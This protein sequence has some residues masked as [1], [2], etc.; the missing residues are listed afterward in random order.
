MNYPDELIFLKNRNAKQR[1]SQFSLNG[2]TIVLTGATSGIGRETAFRLAQDSIHLAIIIRD[3]QKGMELKS[4]IEHLTESKVSVFIADFSDLKSVSKVADEIKTKLDHIDV[5]IHNAGIHSTKKII[6]KDGFEQCFQINYLAS[7]L[8]TQ[9]LLPLL[10]TSKEST[11]L[12][13]NSE[14]HRFSS[15]D[16]TDYN[17]NKHHYTGLRAYGSSKTAQL[18]SVL[19]LNEDKNY[20]NMRFLCMHPGDVKSDIGKNN[21]FLYRLFSKLFIQPMLR[22]P[23]TSAIAIH[24]LLSDPFYREQHEQ[25]YHLTIPEIAA[26]HA[27]D[28]VKAQ[29]LIEL[30]NKLINDFI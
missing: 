25:F 28:Y 29:E 27:R 8:L 24:C 15:F 26:N 14:G 21:G 6:T 9:K 22:D 11:I 10:N 17:F 2:K 3:L 19:V 18:L 7:Y 1:I 16:V 23:K 5:L 4:S 20:K 30:S 13:V 12:Y